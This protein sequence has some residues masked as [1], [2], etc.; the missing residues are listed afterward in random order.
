MKSKQDY[1]D[2]PSLTA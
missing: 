2:N 1:F